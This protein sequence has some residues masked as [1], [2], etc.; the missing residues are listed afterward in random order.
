M[1]LQ[2]DALMVFVM[3]KIVLSHPKNNLK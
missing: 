2:G 3:R 1:A